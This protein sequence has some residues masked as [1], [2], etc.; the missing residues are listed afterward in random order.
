MI[1]PLGDSADSP[2]KYSQVKDGF[3][4][5][6]AAALLAIAA[7]LM[8]LGGIVITRFGLKLWA[9]V[10]FQALA[11]LAPALFLFRGAGALRRAY[12]FLPVRRA[13]LWPSA[14][15]IAGASLAA[16]GVAM[17]ESFWIGEGPLQRN[18]H[19]GLLQY[20]LPGRLMLFALAPALLEEAFFR[21]VLLACLRSWGRWR[22]CAASALLFAGFHLNPEQ[23]VPVFILGAALALATWETGSL[24]PAI[25]GH[26]LHNTL[27]LLLL[28]LPAEPGGQA[29]PLGIALFVIALGLGLGFGGGGRL[30][31]LRQEK[32]FP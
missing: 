6:V 9:V 12:P 14:L 17:A 18:L 22:A 24:W 28:E 25:T 4:P 8:A 23:M 2:S 21:G 11:L 27:V 5:L 16:L 3:R 31:S 13:A 30:I 20:S 15:L 1:E 29:A 19:E 7:F 10:P 32:Y 26:A